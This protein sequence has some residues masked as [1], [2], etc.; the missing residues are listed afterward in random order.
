MSLA[1]NLA[2]KAYI[3]DPLIRM[4]IRRLLRERVQA[5]Y[6]G[7][8]ER[9]YS[10]FETFK[11]YLSTGDISEHSEASKRQHYELPAEFFAA[12]FGKHVKYSSGYWPSEDTTLDESE[13]RMLELTCE[14]AELEDGQDILELG[15]G[16][17]SLTLWMAEKY[18]N[19]KI[20]AVSN[21]EGQKAWIHKAAKQRGLSNIEVIT[22]DIA[23][24]ELEGSF[25]RVVSVEMF[26]HLRNYK[27]LLKKISALLKDDGLLFVHVFCHREYGYRFES[28]GEDNW[29]G[30][31]FFS[32]GVMPSD[33]LFFQFQD[34]L[35][36]QKH[37]IVNGV[38]YAKT[39]RA[40][41]DNI[42]AKKEELLELFKRT[43]GN[44]EA[45]RWFQ[46]WRIF[47]MAYEETFR[48]RNGEEWW[49]SHNLMRKRNQ[50]SLRPQQKIAG[51]QR[52][53]A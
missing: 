1:V 45:E 28:A 15:C 32:G 50:K 2:E 39:C 41:L 52:A 8:A 19:S 36:M 33:Q 20:T 13:D 24:L 40:V 12:V 14:R 46:R 51:L 3:P 6:K 5:L 9:A 35:V 26:E 18:P 43:Y 4:K 27:A 37:W 16:W 38:H 30:K 17:G 23:E 48:F 21:A 47:F 44:Q 34:D 7:G 22:S 53:T 31:Y 42:D 11:T 25:D 49:V 10:R 29:M